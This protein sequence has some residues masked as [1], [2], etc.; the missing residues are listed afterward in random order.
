MSGEGDMFQCTKRLKVDQ[1]LVD[2][3]IQGNMGRSLGL[4]GNP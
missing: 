3:G 1:V 4:V 2:N